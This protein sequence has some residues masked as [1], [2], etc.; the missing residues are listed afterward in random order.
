M[1]WTMSFILEVLPPESG[2][3]L[4]VELIRNGG[5]CRPGRIHLTAEGFIR[6]YLLANRDLAMGLINCTYAI[7]T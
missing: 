5:Q 6:L 4:A 7:T 2:V 1:Q 3:V